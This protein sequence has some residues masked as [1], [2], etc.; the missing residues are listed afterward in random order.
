MLFNINNRLL[1]TIPLNCKH[2]NITQYALGWISHIIFKKNIVFIWK[3]NSIYSIHL[4]TKPKWYNKPPE[5]IYLAKKLQYFKYLH[6]QRY[7]ICYVKQTNKPLYL[8]KLKNQKFVN[9][10]N[11]MFCKNNKMQCFLIILNNQMIYKI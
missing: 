8:E 4:K 10:Q 11:I 6:S 1:K 5:S 3:I 9:S 2:L 7:I